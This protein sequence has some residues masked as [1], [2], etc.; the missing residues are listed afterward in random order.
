MLLPR[1]SP[2][3]VGEGEER[4]DA[5]T[6]QVE[7]AEGAADL[8]LPEGG[9]GDDEVEARA[10]AGQEPHLR[11]AVDLPRVGLG[12]DGHPARIRRY[13]HGASRG[14]EVLLRFV[15]LGLGLAQLAIAPGPA[16]A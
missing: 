3:A 16:A 7:V 1:L 4:V 14:D 5:R 15:L 12:V 2:A 6:N 13:Q 8:R 9:G 10:L 11:H